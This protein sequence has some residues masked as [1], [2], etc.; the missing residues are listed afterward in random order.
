M[1]TGAIAFTLLYKPMPATHPVNPGHQAVQS[2]VAKN[3]QGDQEWLRRI[4][5]ARGSTEKVVLADGST[6][7]VNASSK[8]RY[9]EHFTARYPQHLPGRRRGFL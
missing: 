9:P 2:T 3:E 4:S 7:M 6:I 1:I 8:L 5:T